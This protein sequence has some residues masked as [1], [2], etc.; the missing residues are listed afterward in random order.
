MQH[1]QQILSSGNRCSRQTKNHKCWQHQQTGGEPLWQT[2]GAQPSCQL[3][4]GIPDC[5]EGQIEYKS[6]VRN[7]SSTSKN[8][9]KCVH[10]MG[11]KYDCQKHLNSNQI[12]PNFKCDQKVLKSVPAKP[13]KME[14]FLIKSQKLEL[15]GE[16]SFGEVFKMNDSTVNK[17]VA[18]KMLKPVYGI[19]QKVFRKLI[20]NEV[21]ILKHLQE[22][23]QSYF[24]CYHDYLKKGN[25]HVIVMEFLDQYYDLDRF[26]C[27]RVDWTNGKSWNLSQLKKIQLNLIKGLTVLHQSGIAHNDLKSEN[28]MINPNTLDIKYIDFGGACFGNNCTHEDSANIATLEYAS[29]ERLNYITKPNLKQ[30]QSADRWALGMTFYDLILG[31]RAVQN[32]IKNV[33]FWIRKAMI[34]KEFKRR[35]Y[36]TH[37]LDNYETNYLKTPEMLKELGPSTIKLYI[38]NTYSRRTKIEAY[39]KDKMPMNFHLN[40]FP[41]KGISSN[42]IKWLSNG[43]LNYNPNLRTSLKDAAAYLSKANPF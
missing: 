14:R 32:Q 20:E 1:C 7:E 34:R 27:T 43:F 11:N 8:Y 9:L 31:C 39:L 30:L 28:I 13:L 16:G 21:D 12:V 38:D 40:Y 10:Q 42:Y 2:G 3:K 24:S 4:Q 19:D 37:P 6:C 36:Q 25:N 17:T 41:I 23:C 18:V 35:Y 15:L 22:N 33:D 29:Y 26:I 5:S